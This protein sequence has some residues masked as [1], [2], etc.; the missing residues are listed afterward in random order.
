MA[1]ARYRGGVG[2]Q[3]PVL[4]VGAGGH[5][6][7]SIEVLREAG[8][9]VRGCVASRI[10]AAEGLV[11]LGVPV[12]GTDVDLPDLLTGGP[13]VFVAVGAN[14]ARQR[15]IETCLRAGGTLV[16]ALSPAA[17]VSPSASIEPGSLVMPGAVVNAMASIG[18]G[19]V[20]NTGAT[21][22]HEC[23][24]RDAVHVAPGAV[25]A[26]NVQ[27]GEG[28]LVGLGAR[29][30]PGLR[31]GRWAVVGAGAVVVSDVP[32]GA[33]VVGIPARAIRSGDHDG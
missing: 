4:V 12:L 28:A 22:E 19:A 5:A 18:Q 7:V 14:D 13:A 1:L 32:D 9:A 2:D 26:G 8:H 30:A 29:V 17:V 25:L 27:V 11:R 16:T 31:I 3:T 10:G 24:V 6:L 23:V 20:I 15:L 33:T 21:V